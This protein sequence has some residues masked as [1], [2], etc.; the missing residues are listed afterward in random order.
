MMFA[1]S[2]GQNAQQKKL[3][4]ALQQD[5]V[6]E[7]NVY[8][9]AEFG[10][11]PDAPSEAIVWKNGVKQILS[12]GRNRAGA[13]A[14]FVSGS[15]VYVAG[16]DSDED[17]NWV[18]TVWKNGVAQRIGNN[19]Y[20]SEASSVFV[21]DKDVYAAGHEYNA[22]GNTVAMLWKNGKAKKLSDGKNYATA[23]SV[24]VSG[25][26]VYVAGHITN[27]DNLWVATVW[28]NGVAQHLSSRSEAFSVY[29][30]GSDVYVAGHEAMEGSDKDIAK[31]WKNGVAQ[32]LTDGNSWA[33]AKAVY[34]SGSDVY[35]AG[36]DDNNAEGI[37]VAT[38]WKNGVVQNLTDGTNYAQAYSV[39]VF[40]SDV[41][42]CGTETGEDGNDVATLWKN[43]IPLK[44]SDYFYGTSANSVFVVTGS[45][46]AKSG[47]TA[48][49]STGNVNENASD[50]YIK[51][52]E[53]YNAI[54]R[55][56]MAFY[57]TENK[58]SYKLNAFTFVNGYEMYDMDE[59]HEAHR[60]AFI[61]LQD[62][63]VPT[64]VLEF[65]GVGAFFEVLR[66]QE[67][68][69]Y[70]F[71]FDYRA[72]LDLSADGTS[73]GSSGA[74]S[75]SYQKMSIEKD[76]CKE[77]VL[78]Y[79]EMNSDGSV[80][81]FIGDKKVTWSNYNS[82][83][84]SIGTKD[85]VWH[86]YTAADFASVQKSALNQQKGMLYT[87]LHNTRKMIPFSHI[88]SNYG[89][90]ASKFL[91]PSGWNAVEGVTHRTGGFAVVD[92]EL[93]YY[94]NPGYTSPSPIT[95][96]RSNLQGG[97]VKKITDALDNFG[98]VWA[99]GDRIIYSTIN[100]DDE[101][102]GVFCYDAKTAKSTMLLNQVHYI[103]N[104]T[105]V[106]F[107]DEHVYYRLS[108]SD[109]LWR[110]GWDGTNREP[111]TINIPDNLYSV[112]DDSY[113]CVSVDYATGAMPIHCYS[114]SNENLKATCAPE[115]QAIFTIRDG[116]AYLYEGSTI[117]KVNIDSGNK[118]NLANLPSDMPESELVDWYVM[119]NMLYL[120][121]RSHQKDNAF[122]LRLYKVPLS[123][124]EVTYL[125][126]EWIEYES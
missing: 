30:S 6:G 29:V 97:N 96:Y 17:R 125:D 122:L 88:A 56:D 84:S 123:G 61:N 23:N 93:I 89:L 10:Y 83:S 73:Y 100:D 36:Y 48:D 72:L 50:N 58:K 8:V 15:D 121:I 3:T 32:N 40:G 47:K 66:Y 113:Y 65:G 31:L 5:E 67:G 51:A 117:F 112:E 101:R 119:T 68:A 114:I 9:A 45:N 13:N 77:E 102:T 108:N 71:Y 126:V 85:V 39:R 110:V 43:G 74:S 55:S 103:I 79:S 95:L 104:F 19:K 120:N 42:V 22:E 59:P 34:V 86:D 37:R 52:M 107:D 78:C 80:S 57:S 75:G 27:E 109:E 35:V 41:Y 26:D 20:H 91:C 63:E 94:C 111:A 49:A 33:A 46:V 118:V 76:I 92:N 64:L 82:F 38:V 70:G 7:P 11:G 60:Y 44:I 90:Y 28:K 25:K 24:Y 99:V 53:A 116:W 16:Y 87:L 115:A 14:V 105:L 1:V 81:Y 62:D 124:G 69:V 106:T 12:N 18:A 4:D 54:L 2:C 21:S 98:K